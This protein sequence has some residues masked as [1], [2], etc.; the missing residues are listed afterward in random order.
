MINFYCKDDNEGNIVILFKIRRPELK[1]VEFC[2][3]KGMVA[4]G[5][6]LKITVTMMENCGTWDRYNLEL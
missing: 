6:T 3:K 1:V 4:P 2:P 5:D